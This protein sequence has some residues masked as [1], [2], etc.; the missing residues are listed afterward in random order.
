MII[1]NRLQSLFR[2]INLILIGIP[3]YDF[4]AMLCS[5]IEYQLKCAAIFDSPIELFSHSKNSQWLSNGVQSFRALCSVKVYISAMKMDNEKPKKNYRRTICIAV[6]CSCCNVVNF[7]FDTKRRTV[8]SIFMAYTAEPA[9][10][11]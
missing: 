2:Y 5:S 11:N 4:T 6:N 10:A 7:R 9:T 3:S 1:S 8:F